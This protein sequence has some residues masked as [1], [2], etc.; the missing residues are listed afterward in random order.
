LK[1]NVE[2]STNN[3]SVINM[4]WTKIPPTTASKPDPPKKQPNTE[5]LFIKLGINIKNE[6]GTYKYLTDVL[7]ELREVWNELD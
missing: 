5:E 2:I 1:N 4:S 3:R 7:D 6:D